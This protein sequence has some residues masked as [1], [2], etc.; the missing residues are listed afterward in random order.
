MVRRSAEAIGAAVPRLTVVTGYQP[1]LIRQALAG[2]DAAFIHNPG[3]SS[4]LGS[5]LAVGIGGLPG[6]A[7]G[8]VVG[9]ADMPFVLPRTV[10]ALI[11]AFT[12]AVSSVVV[13]LHNGKRG[14]PVVWPKRCF[15]ELARLSGDVGGR[16]LLRGE[17]L[18]E[19]A[20]DDPGVLKDVD[21]LGD[22]DQAET[23]SLG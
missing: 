16:E 10:S 23:G 22:L 20:V 3:F 12:G 1:H 7:T 9:L 11:A 21:T 5:S 6:S 15:S 13:P 14:N 17:A 4:G 18:L 19:L 8:V 2:L